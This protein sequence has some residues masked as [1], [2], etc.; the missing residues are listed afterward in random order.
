MFVYIRYMYVRVH[1]YIDINVGFCLFFS[2][3]PLECKLHPKILEGGPTYS[4][5]PK[6]LLNE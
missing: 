3:P 1:I 6:Y 5:S 4:S 2:F